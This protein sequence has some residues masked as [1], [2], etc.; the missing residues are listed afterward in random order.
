MSKLFLDL[1]RTLFR[2]KDVPLIWQQIA[3]MYPSVDADKAYLDQPSYYVWSEGLYYHDFSHQLK[4]LGLEPSQVYEHVR[5]SELADGRMSFEGANEF[6]ADVMAKHDVAVLTYG[7]SDYQGFKASLCPA[8]ADVPII[9]TLRPKREYLQETGESWLVDDKPLG[10][11]LPEHVSFIQ[12]SLEGNQ[13][14]VQR[15]PVCTSLLEV[16][17]IVS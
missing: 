7:L 13:A 17:R 14:P 15:W 9:T 4:D 16:G 2:T 12:V 5:S 6:I 11:E 1:D 3:A 10:N 8:L